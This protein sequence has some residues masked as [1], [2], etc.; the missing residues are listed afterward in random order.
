MLLYHNRAATSKLL[1]RRRCSTTHD[2]PLPP[3]HPPPTCPFFLTSDASPKFQ[4]PIQYKAKQ[5]NCIVPNFNTKA[6][7][8]PNL[9]LKTINGNFQPQK[10]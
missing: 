3:T 8:E 10:A 9:I 2:I 6:N 1:C 4:H 5:Q 7:I